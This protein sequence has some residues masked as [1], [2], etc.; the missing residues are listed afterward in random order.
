MKFE[1]QMKMKIEDKDED[2]GEMNGEMKWKCKLANGV[3]MASRQRGGL[4]T[5]F[6]SRV[7]KKNLDTGV[8]ESFRWVK[9]PSAVSEKHGLGL[10]PHLWAPDTTG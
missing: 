9:F 1:M 4:D 2:E 6:N 5:H 3:C 8:M 10:K 7:T